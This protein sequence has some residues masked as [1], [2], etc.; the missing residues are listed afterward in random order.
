MA[1]TFVDVF[2]GLY[3]QMVLVL[4]VVF[5]IFTMKTV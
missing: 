1:T 2:G 3:Y 4:V 5:Q